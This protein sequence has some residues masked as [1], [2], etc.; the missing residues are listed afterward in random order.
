MPPRWKCACPRARAPQKEKPSIS[1]YGQ[2]ANVDKSA[3]GVISFMMPD[4]SKKTS[5][6]EDTLYTATE[7][8]WVQAYAGTEHTGVNVQINGVIV[9]YSQ[10]Y[11]GDDSSGFGCLV[12]VDIGDTYKLE[13]GWGVTVYGFNFVPCKGVV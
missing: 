6:I 4:W 13:S 2:D 7:Q 12:P 5:K 1:Y 8:G 11:G 3:N 9:A 10:A